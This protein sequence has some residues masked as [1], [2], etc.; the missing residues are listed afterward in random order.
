MSRP[1]KRNG[2]SSGRS[3]S[4]L[5]SSILVIGE[6][7]SVASWSGIYH[8]QE[9]SFLKEGDPFGFLGGVNLLCELMGKMQDMCR[10]V[11]L[12]VV[13]T[14]PLRMYRDKH[15]GQFCSSVHPSAM[16]DPDDI[17]QAVENACVAVDAAP[18]AVV[19]VDSGS[20]A[21]TPDSMRVLK[22]YMQIWQCPVF[23]LNLGEY[24]KIS[25]EYDYAAVIR[26]SFCGRNQICTCAWKILH[27]HDKEIG[28]F[29]DKNV[30][31]AY[32]KGS[33]APTLGLGEMATAYIVSEYVRDAGLGRDLSKSLPFLKHTFTSIPADKLLLK[34]GRGLVREYEA[35]KKRR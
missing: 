33:K 9:G 2:S 15:R 23:L 16:Y 18:E 32:G 4:S 19:L 1:R 28:G 29:C 12:P 5:R 6:Q 34:F 10:C 7:L 30:F 8:P 26:Q 11:Q 24:T 27:I 20:G 35:S 14:E 17:T 22:P 3:A 21:M 31:Q 13:R 25:L